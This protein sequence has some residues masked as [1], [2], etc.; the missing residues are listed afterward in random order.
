MQK[1]ILNRLLTTTNGAIASLALT[2]TV[3]QAQQLALFE[4]Q[5]EQVIVVGEKTDRSMKETSSS[6]SVITEE[7]LKNMQSKALRDALS[8]V[9]NVVALSGAVPDIRGVSGNGSAGG[10]N[11]IT[12]GARSRV[13]ILV[14][15][16]AEPFVADFTGDTGLWD[17]EQIEVYRGP[18]STSN[19]RNSLAGAIYIKTS[20]PTDDW[21]GAARVAYRDEDQYIDTA[22]VISGPIVEDTLSMRL[23]VQKRDAETIT[24][25]DGYASNPPDYDLNEIDTTRVRAKLQWTPTD[26][27]SAL[28][29][30]STNK[31][32]GD[33]GRIYYSL[34]NL[35]D[36]QRV[37][38]RDIT[39]DVATTSLRLEND[40]SERVSAEILL[41]YM[42]Y[43]WGFDSYDPDPAD[44]QV[45]TFE[46]SNLTLDAKLNF[47]PSET[48]S[49]FVGV[50]Y[51][52]REQDINSVGS[53]PYFGEDES[54][55]K[56]VYGEVTFGLTDKWS[57]ITGA[58][59]EKE[60]QLRDFT[61]LPIVAQLD[62]DNSI[63][64]PKLVAQYELS[65]ETTLAL[66]Y[67]KGYNAAGGALN[68]VA[69]EYYY[70][71]DET[72]DTVEFSTR[73]NLADDKVFLSTN[74]FYNQYDGY[75]ALSS[76]R[77]IT[78]M[79]EVTTYGLEAE[80]QA[81]PNNQT[82]LTAG[83]GVLSTEI[84]DAGENYPGVNGN[85]LNSAPQLTAKFGVDFWFTEQF[86][87]GAT[88]S[89]VDEYYGDFANTDERVG[90]DYTLVRLTAS[91]E[92]ENWLFNGF[93]NNALDED[94]IVSQEPVSGRY[95][96]GYAA[97]V[98]PR[99]VG[100]SLTYRFQ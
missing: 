11:S 13:S 51:F 80:L 48:I 42:D 62:E 9:P 68:F 79:D 92:L 45:L 58:R 72:V 18:Q 19:G 14:D 7:A 12:G 97:I 69:Q 64:L 82:K 44:L 73:S 17:I 55:S 66:S 50:F 25:E 74:V 88:V 59:Y 99:N 30:H 63:F 76:S 40:F 8:E 37:F 60:T 24:S 67:R 94:A 75:Q 78:N 38:Y 71:D 83:L 53:F 2:A 91:Y 54:D 85:E 84:D 87:V 41:A 49:G 23:S 32:Q 70:Y 65:D 56:G 33:T 46:E 96:E 6:V 86:Q 26:S 57:L 98:D 27:F 77:A 93:V 47:T 20:E 5:I 22:A 15:G 21:L 89:Y 1:T 52:D 3:A 31:E 39:T 28:L 43:E 16:V 61:Y 100:V 95:P 34:V 81:Y 90:G 4:G 29:S 35:D 36:R 10:F